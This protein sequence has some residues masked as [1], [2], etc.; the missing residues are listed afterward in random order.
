MSYMKHMLKFKCTPDQQKDQDLILCRVSILS[1]G[2]DNFL[3]AC[4]IVL[5]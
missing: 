5:M 3:S 2:S 4:F 1:D